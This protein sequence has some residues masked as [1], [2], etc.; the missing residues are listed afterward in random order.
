M[1]AKRRN[2]VRSPATGVSAGQAVSSRNGQSH[3]PGSDWVAAAIY[4]VFALSLFLA[5]SASLD[6]KFALP[7]AIVLSAAVLGL[8]ILLFVRNRRGRAVAPQRSALLLSLALGAWWMVSTP[9][10]LHLPTALNGEYDYYNGLWTH[11]CWLA[12]FVA[13]LSI[14]MNLATTRRIV[15]FVAAAIV[16][17]AFINIAEI[18]GLSSFGLKEVSTLGDRVAASALMNFAI[19]F[20]AVALL[21][22][23]HWGT[24][25][26]LGGLLV[27]LVGS[28]FLSQGRGPWMGLVVA[29]VILAVGLIRSKAD[30]RIAVAMLI[31]I[32]V[33]AGLAAKLSPA[34]AERFATL[35]Q[36]SHDESLRQRFVFYRAALRAIREHPLAGIGFENF[37]NS[38][39]SYRAAE[40]I[41]F[42]DNVI[43]TMVHNGYLQTALTNGIPALLLYFALLAVAL[44]A[45][46][47]A[48]SRE[49][50]RD[51]HALLLAFLAALGAYLVQDLV[52]WLDMALT[53]AFW[54]ML[55]LAL[56]LA[57][58][59][60]PRTSTSWMKPVIATFSGLMV[61]LSL[62]LFSNLYA[63]ASADACL[64]N[65]QALDVRTQWPETESLI[66]KALSSL[67]GDSRTEMV[68]G[69]I[70]AN[71][72]LSA[73]DA[74]AYVRSRELLE[75][76]YEHNRFDR[77]RL[78][79]IVALETAALELGQIGT[80]SE[81]AQN[82]IDTLAAT[83]RDNPGFHD[84][85]AKFFAAQ[86]RFG[87]A[88]AAI[89]VAR[90]LAP[91]D[92]RFRSLEMEYEARLKQ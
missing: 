82:A 16:P 46:V 29:A 52:G 15:A 19:P 83:D 32:V 79:N 51:R 24:K 64:F 30:W 35:T 3:H 53:S 25:A 22:V 78:A 31:S 57:S 39:P 50:D 55:G 89:R 49:K 63:R 87:E 13:S 56:N 73:H 42:F 54:V 48:L 85:K 74:N 66:D 4:G 62:Y 77:L 36:I 38:Y 33:L 75:S 84:F 2:K 47:R 21:R 60:S 70:F 71:R 58:Q 7:K 5:C 12:L 69:Q 68:A 65:A 41:Y 37:R 6:S 34:A 44:S 10:A 14:P 17:V 67:G 91:Q 11:L 80:A 9:F 40:D 76:S 8:G 23:R 92:E 45:L 20:A 18:S 90:R 61:L 1:A 81:F 88:L 26:G 72:F 28:E 59:N 27:L 86:G 43:P